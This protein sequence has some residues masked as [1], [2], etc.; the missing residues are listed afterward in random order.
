MSDRLRPKIIEAV[1]QCRFKMVNSLFRNGKRLILAAG[2]SQRSRKNGPATVPR[3]IA[4]E[5]REGSPCRNNIIDQNIGIPGADGT[6]EAW[7]KQEPRPSVQLRAANAGNLYDFLVYWAAQLR[8]EKASIRERQGIPRAARVRD[9]TAALIVVKCGM[10]N[11]QTGIK[12]Q[13]NRV[14]DDAVHRRL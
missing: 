12:A 2:A 4:P 1:A 14:S 5:S 7:L 6:P 10:R 3:D 13:C 8:F 9:V 11:Q